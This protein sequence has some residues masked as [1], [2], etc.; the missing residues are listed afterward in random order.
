LFGLLVVAYAT[1]GIGLIVQ[2]RQGENGNFTTIEYS[3]PGLWL[4]MMLVLTIAVGL[5][6]MSA[7]V[8]RSSWKVI[9]A[10]FL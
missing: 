10:T 8:A 1:W 4:P 7:R 6:V 5:S 9:S 3:H 2:A